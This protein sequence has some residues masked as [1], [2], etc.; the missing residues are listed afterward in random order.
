MVTQCKAV[1]Q[2]NN[3]I[4]KAKSMAAMA[5]SK[6]EEL[7]KQAEKVKKLKEEADK[8]IAKAK[9]LAE[10]ADIIIAIFDSSR[11]LNE[12]DMDILN[13]VFCKTSL[14]NML[15]VTISTFLNFD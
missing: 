13:I 15:R 1:T 9:E 4:G 5:Q 8:K 14:S 2:I 6:A 10:S 12:E 7:K 11:D 3:A